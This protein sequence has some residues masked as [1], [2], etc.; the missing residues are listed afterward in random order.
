[1]HMLLCVCFTETTAFFLFFNCLPY[2]VK[3]FKSCSKILVLQG[4]SLA[5]SEEHGTLD[6]GVV[7]SGPMLSGF[8][9]CFCLLKY[10]LETHKFCYLWKY[11]N[12]AIKINKFLTINAD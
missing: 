3:V 2:D 10:K 4:A 12:N 1:M 6:L 9:F 5:Q 8:C 7:S 11:I